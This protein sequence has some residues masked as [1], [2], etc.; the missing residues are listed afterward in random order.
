MYG[1]LHCQLYRIWGCIEGPHPHLGGLENR[2]V[3]ILGR[4]SLAVRPLRDL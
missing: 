1:W 4:I 2:G 3:H